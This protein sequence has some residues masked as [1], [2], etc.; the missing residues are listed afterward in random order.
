MIARLGFKA[1][2][3]KGCCFPPKFSG[4]KPVWWT[5]ARFAASFDRQRIRKD[6]GK[7]RRCGVLYNES[8]KIVVLLWKP[9][10]LIFL[11]F[12]LDCTCLMIY[13]WCSPKSGFVWLCLI[14]WYPK[15][16]VI[17]AVYSLQ[18]IPILWYPHVCPVATSVP[19]CALRRRNWA[20]L[21]RRAAQLPASWGLRIVGDPFPDMEDMSSNIGQK[22]DIYS[23]LYIY[24]IIQYTYI[25]K[26]YYLIYDITYIYIIYIPY[27]I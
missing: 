23:I 24:D 4:T 27:K 13:F 19:K 11:L 15:S 17:R 8:N 22:L 16:M 25:N 12:Q 3:G 7:M 21:N 2:D 26:R 10:S 6:Q 14:F 18:K 5:F 9:I 20:R 1:L